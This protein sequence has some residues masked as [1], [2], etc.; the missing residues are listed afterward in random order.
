MAPFNPLPSTT[1][2]GSSIQTRGPL[3]DSRGTFSVPKLGGGTGGSYGGGDSGCNDEPTGGIPPIGTL[4]SD[5]GV[6]GGSVDSHD[7]PLGG[8]Y[9]G[10][11]KHPNITISESQV[12]EVVPGSKVFV[13]SQD[14]PDAGLCGVFGAVN[15]ALL[16]QT[17]TI[18]GTDASKIFDQTV[19]AYADTRDATGSYFYSEAA[20]KF[21][22]GMNALSRAEDNGTRVFD[23]PW[24]GHRT[25][26]NEMGKVARFYEN[27]R[28]PTQ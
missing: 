18:D 12:V 21:A 20:K 4:T 3:L 22:E 9:P 6:F 13:P 7:W 1:G 15:S 26:A 28:Q 27:P 19:Q 24:Q 5:G 14:D 11:P 23:V 16:N 10:D 17:C 25:L 8:H 2:P